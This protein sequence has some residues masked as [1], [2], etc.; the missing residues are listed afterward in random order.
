MNPRFFDFRPMYEVSRPGLLRLLGLSRTELDGFFNEL[1]PIHR[2]LLNEVGHVASAGAL[3]QAPLLYVLVRATEP[4]WV[5]ETGI[6]SGYSARLALEAL[7]RNGHGHLDSIGIDVF[8]LGQP[9][10]ARPDALAGRAVGWLV[11][12]RL[13]S[14]WGL[15][16]GRS[17]ERLP[18]LL[19]ARPGELDMFLH[20]SLHQYPVMKAE[21]E[22]AARALRPGGLLL[23]HD[24]HAS[25]AWAEFLAHKEL[26]GAEELDH[27][28][29]VVRLPGSTTGG[30][31]TSPST[32]QAPPIS[33][34][35][36]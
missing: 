18:A 28:L 33:P 9:G 5:V 11:P 36:A 22:L 27:D 31:P 19:G 13:R 17:E 7:A 6:S 26:H 10:E 30:L 2:E 16:I 34:P 29:G 12:P 21:Y 15:I 20:D 24:I 4:Q 1:E 14:Q 32:A 8:A 25:P 3:I 23:S 35:S